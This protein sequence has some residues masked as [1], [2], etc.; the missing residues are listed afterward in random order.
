MDDRE[1][2]RFE[3]FSRVKAFGEAR[4]DAFTAGSLGKELLG[5]VAAVVA[6]L[7]G[8][9]ATQASGG[10]SA[11]QGTASKAAARAALRDDL[12]AINRTAVALGVETPGVGDKFRLPR[13]ATDQVWLATARSFATDAAPLK[14]E[15]VRY[16]MPADFLA[17]LAADI[18][19]FER[20]SGSQSAGVGNQVA[21]T[22]AIDEAIER[23]MK[24][25]RQ[26]DSVVRNKFRGDA[27]ALAAWQSASHTQRGAR[28]KQPTTT[29]PTTETPK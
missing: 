11:R 12:E 2:R 13:N 4:G 17:D 1:R 7:E 5:A 6:E 28:A 18:A 26:L 14:A 10:S 16:E 23:G 3:M 21:A 27:S 29:T 8:H 22:A 9:A 25:I 19:D 15:F 24:A 20:A